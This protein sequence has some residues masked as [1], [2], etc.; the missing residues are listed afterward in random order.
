MHATVKKKVELRCSSIIAIDV[1]ARWVVVSVAPHR[2]KPKFYGK[3]RE[4]R[5]KYFY[6]RRKL[7]KDVA[8]RLMPM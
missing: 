8:T 6:L 3:I 4:V 2:N 5:G 7:G 1:G